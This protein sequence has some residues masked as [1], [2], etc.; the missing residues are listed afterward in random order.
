MLF[1]VSLDAL[2]IA[3]S[4]KSLTPP[5]P[6]LPACYHASHP[7]PISSDPTQASQ[8]SSQIPQLRV[9]VDAERVS[10]VDV[11]ALPLQALSKL[12]DAVPV[13]GAKNNTQVRQVLC[14]W[15]LRK[16]AEGERGG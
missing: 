3:A 8:L 7:F 2:C 16:V 13:R 5:M 11:D 10:Q 4:H 14:A 1:L 6:F 9:R 15:L 12:Q